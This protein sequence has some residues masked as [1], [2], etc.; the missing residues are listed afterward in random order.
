MKNVKAFSRTIEIVSACIMVT[1]VLLVTASNP[2]DG[3]EFI[4]GPVAGIA[5][6]IIGWIARG[7]VG[8]LLGE[9][10]NAQ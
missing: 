5:G 7:V 4:K 6:C 10:S 1:V 9:Q 2:W 8:A 3:D